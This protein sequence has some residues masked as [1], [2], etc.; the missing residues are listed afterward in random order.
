MLAHHSSTA[1]FIC[2][3]LAIRFVNDDP[4]KSLLD[5]MVKTFSEKDGNIKEVLITMVCAPEFWD[6]KAVR[7]KTKSPFELA[8]GAA[9]SLHA[10]ITQPYQLYNWVNKMG[11]K[12]YYYQAPTGFPDNAQY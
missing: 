4:P 9:R 10:E 8:I 11:E 12:I 3:K 1:A 7:E 6:Q 5:K 2:K